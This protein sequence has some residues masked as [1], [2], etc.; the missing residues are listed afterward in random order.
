MNLTS[1]EFFAVSKYKHSMFIQFVYMSASR[2]TRLPSLDILAPISPAEKISPTT[3]ELFASG[4]FSYHNA[5]VSEYEP[6]VFDRN[7]SP[8]ISPENM[9]NNLIMDPYANNFYQFQKSDSFL[10]DYSYDPA[11]L[12]GDTYG[13]QYAPLVPNEEYRC[14]EMGCNKVFE[15]QSTL[16]SHLRSHDKEEG[17]AF[18]CHKCHSTFRRSH[19]LKRHERSLHSDF[20]PFQCVQCA[21]QFS[22][23]VN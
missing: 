23:M 4:S 22:R 9:A 19:D 15:K 21:K 10:T 8:P 1:K 17:R 3:A 16:K 5:S 12:I 20:K 6:P 2:K 14:P 11:M 13:F 7:P 18:E